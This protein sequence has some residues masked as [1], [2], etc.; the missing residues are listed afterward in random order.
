MDEE[1]MEDVSGM[2]TR[3]QWKTLMDSYLESLHPSK[4]HKS[5]ISQEVYDMIFR[6]LRNPDATRLG[7]PQFRFWARKMFQLV[8]APNDP[9][10][11]VVTN[12]GRPVAIKEHIYD[13]LCMCHYECGHGGRDKTCKVL[14]EYYTWVPKELISNFVKVCPTCEPRRAMALKAKDR[15]FTSDIGLTGQE[16]SSTSSSRFSV[17]RL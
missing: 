2:P 15:K 16:E 3:A 14:R 1:T 10:V 17:E 6:T 7:T 13:I 5:L 11:L 8:E 9:D 12:G 4:R